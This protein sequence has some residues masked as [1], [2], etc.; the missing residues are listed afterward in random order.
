MS[1]NARSERSGGASESARRN[2]RTPPSSSPAFSFWSPSVACAD[3]INSFALGTATDFGCVAINFFRASIRLS[4]GNVNVN[5]TSSFSSSGSDTTPLLFRFAAGD[6]AGRGDLFSATSIA[7]AG[8]DVGLGLSTA[9]D[10][11]E[12]VGCWVC[13]GSG[14]S[15]GAGVGVGL[16]IT[17]GVG[18]ALGSGVGV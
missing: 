12:G 3:K 13:D 17:S 14:V 10:S 9:R 16:S 11:G 6:R 8:E 5:S 1:I 15:D 4:T 18:V 2:S 7:A